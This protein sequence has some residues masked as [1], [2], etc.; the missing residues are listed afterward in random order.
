MKNQKFLVENSQV[1]VNLVGSLQGEL[2]AQVRE[3]MLTYISD[4]YCDFKVDF[5]N[6]NNINST[7]LGMLVNIQKRALQQGGDIIIHGLH[8][9]VKAAFDRT[10]LSK[11]FTILDCQNAVA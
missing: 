10:R 3:T 7:G 6:V 9:T 4:G 8:G 2:A 5:S 11:A 1:V